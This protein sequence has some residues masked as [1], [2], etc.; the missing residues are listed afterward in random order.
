MS[1]SVKQ[2]ILVFR[3]LTALVTAT[4]F[5][6]AGTPA[7][8]AVDPVQAPPVAA[9]VDDAYLIHGGDEL[10]VIVY[11]E[12]DLTQAVTVL[13]SGTIS[14][15][16]IG[17]I[18]VGGLTPTQASAALST[19]LKHYLRQPQVSV[20]VVKEGP[21]AILVLG[22]VT[23]PGKYELP[24]RSRLTDAIASAGGL[25]ITDGNFPDARLATSKGD[26]KQVS[27]Q[28]LLHDGDTSQNIPLGDEMT[29]YVP[30]PLT[31][32]VQ[33]LGAVEKPGDVLVHEGDR[34]SMAIAR[35][36][37]GAAANADLNHITV[38]R[39]QPS[40]GTQTMNVNLYDV[41]KSGDLSRD[42]VMQKNDLV[43]VP[44]SAGHNDRISGPAS[45]LYTLS[46]LFIP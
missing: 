44:A 20:V 12:K 17:E 1:S 4:F 30:S 11:G 43:Y 23:K 6:V 38:R 25:G 27:L 33:V 36:G 21:L 40:G 32:Q 29:V 5:T 45:I 31:L 16:L 15:P 41:H 39:V 22:N 42:P 26:V 9:R 35:A 46:H 7:F 14:Y 28:K 13:P 24:S 37:S 18:R 8:A 19:S 2:G 10:N 34:L 3:L